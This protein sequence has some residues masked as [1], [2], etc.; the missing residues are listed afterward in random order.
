MGSIVFAAVKDVHEDLVI[1][2]GSIITEAILL[3]V[4]IVGAPATLRALIAATVS[5][6]HGAQLTEEQF[7]E[8][9]QLERDVLIQQLAEREAEG[10]INLD[11]DV[12]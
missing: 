3:A 2:A 7:A 9:V 6:A 1:L 5:S 12:A 4:Q 11:E 8:L 10:L